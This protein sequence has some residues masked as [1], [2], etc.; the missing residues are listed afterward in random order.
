[1]M[2]CST[3]SH[4]ET[5]FESWQNKKSKQ[6]EWIS[7]CN[8]MLKDGSKYSAH[9]IPDSTKSIQLVRL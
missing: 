9:I 2:Y 4:I 5:V 8:V 7:K 3:I 1:M 6:A